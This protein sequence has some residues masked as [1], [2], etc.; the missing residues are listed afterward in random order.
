MPSMRTS[1]M[2]PSC[3]S[4]MP[5]GV[6][7]KITS[8][9]TSVITSLTK[10]TSSHGPNS[11][12]LVRAVWRTSPLTRALQLK[13]P[14][15]TSA[16]PTAREGRTC[17]TPSRASTGRRSSG[18]ARGDVV[19]AREPDHVLGAS[20]GVDVA[21]AVADHDAQLGLVVDAADPV[22][23]H[24]RLARPDHRRRRLDEDHR[25]AG[26]R[27]AHLGDVV[28]IVQTDAHD[29]GRRDRTRGAA[30]RASGTTPSGSH[31][32]NGSSLI[33]VTVASSAIRSGSHP[34][35]AGE[36]R[37]CLNP[38]S[39]RDDVSGVQA[40]TTDRPV[41]CDVHLRTKSLA[42]G[43]SR[44]LGSKVRSRSSPRAPPTRLR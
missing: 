40:S 15:S 29:L 34:R 23:H 44:P 28:A 26:H 17:R 24:D 2:S 43:E 12:S 41:S 13:S 1:T 35:E 4:P 8:P 42:G 32:A 20:S 7:V 16:P 9:G 33:R 19:A 38:G 5:P 31:A 3:S 39:I 37:A 18:V 36:R 11:M 6:P 25:L 10:L 27:V 21:C 22:G 14:G 30:R